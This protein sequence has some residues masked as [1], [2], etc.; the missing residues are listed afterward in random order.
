MY[1]WRIPRKFPQERYPIQIIKYWPY[2][3]NVLL[4]TDHRTKFTA[5]Y[6]NP[7]LLMSLLPLLNVI[8]PLSTPKGRLLAHDTVLVGRK[9]GI[10]SA[11]DLCSGHLLPHS[12]GDQAC[13]IRRE[14]PYLDSPDTGTRN[15]FL[16]NFPFI[17]LITLLM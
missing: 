2:S 8:F 11:D 3:G 4:F 6:I 1:E 7:F 9:G 17:T 16:K 5:F 14:G 12:R 10:T 15:I 13:G